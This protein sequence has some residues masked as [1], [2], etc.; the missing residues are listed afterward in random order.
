MSLI[1]IFEGFKFN[2]VQL[3]NEHVEGLTLHIATPD[4]AVVSG[5]SPTQ[6]FSIGKGLSWNKCGDF[7]LTPR[8]TQPF[9]QNCPQ[10]SPLTTRLSLC[11][12]QPLPKSA[13]AQLSPF[14]T[15]SYLK[16]IKKKDTINSVPEDFEIL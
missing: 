1:N 6:L 14:P 9:V 4:L 12:T 8:P 16:K 13:F 15:Q 5:T 7:Q 3:M 11:P 2:H 10:L